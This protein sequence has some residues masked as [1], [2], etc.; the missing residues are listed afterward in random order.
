MGAF[1]VLLVGLI[2]VLLGYIIGKS[3][4]N[5]NSKEASE[6]EKLKRRVAVLLSENEVLKAKIAS[7]SHVLGFSPEPL[8][9]PPFDHDLASSVLGK[10]VEEN[11]LKVIEG[12]GPKIEQLFKTSGILTWKGLAEMSVDRCNEILNK[13]GDQFARH[14]PSTWPRQARLAYEGKWRD[15][16]VWQESLQGGLE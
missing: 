16:K 3:A 13:A 4:L 6:V 10:D 15:L 2:G 14:N 7:G 11:D 1:L 12:V 5:S 9:H 8:V